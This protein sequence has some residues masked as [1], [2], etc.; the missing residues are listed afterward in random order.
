MQS[1]PP[2]IIEIPSPI[3]GARAY[4][5]GQC[6]VLVQWHLAYGWHMSTAHPD[7][8]PTWDEIKTARY[9]LLPQDITMAML[10]PP[11]GE[12]VNVHNNC[13][14]LHQVPNDTGCRMVLP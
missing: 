13:F 4:R 7:R 2:Q 3:P 11:P 1:T 14:H 12:F 6:S 8:Y 5:M 10:L 9:Q